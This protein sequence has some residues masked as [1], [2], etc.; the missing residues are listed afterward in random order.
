MKN[1]RARA[2]STLSF[3]SEPVLYLL[4]AREA[5]ANT[6]HRNKTFYIVDPQQE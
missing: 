3:I 2:D 5:N 6:S 1:L 4:A